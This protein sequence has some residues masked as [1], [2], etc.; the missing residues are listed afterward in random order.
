MQEAYQTFI[1]TISSS[2]SI[3]YKC[4]LNFVS[5]SCYISV[6]RSYSYIYFQAK[7]LLG[8]TTTEFYPRQAQEIKMDMKEGG[9]WKGNWQLP[10][11][12]FCQ[13]IYIYLCI[14]K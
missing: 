6:Y 13:A 14:S 4:K 8:G 1:L 12:E 5:L 9:I 2:K 11:M 3:F 7:L 10:E